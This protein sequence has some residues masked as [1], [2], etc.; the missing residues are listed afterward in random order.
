MSVQRLGAEIGRI[1]GASGNAAAKAATERAARVIEA[2]LVLRQAS[3]LSPTAGR[4][5]APFWERKSTELAMR[6]L[7]IWASVKLAR[8]AG[9]R[10][11][12]KL[13][14]IL[15]RPR[16]VIAPDDGEFVGPDGLRE[17]TRIDGPVGDGFDAKGLE[18]QVRTVTGNLEAPELTIALAVHHALGR[19]RTR[20]GEEYDGLIYSRVYL[21]WFPRTG[22]YQRRTPFHPASCRDGDRGLIRDAIR[23]IVGSWRRVDERA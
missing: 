23:G 6:E 14:A 5:T 20:D 7:D 1:R 19:L 12:P 18:E 9:I 16:Q 13:D 10:E 11:C 21:E 8:A 15:G 4:E 3:A 2:R 22:T 17:P